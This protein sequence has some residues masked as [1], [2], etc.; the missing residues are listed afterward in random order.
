MRKSLGTALAVGFLTIAA[1][2]VAQTAPQEVRVT[3]VDRS[4]RAFFSAQ[5]FTGSGNFWISPRTT[6]R[7][8]DQ[9]TTYDYFK[10]GSVVR[11]SSHMEGD[12]AIADDVM[13]IQ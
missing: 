5:W 12:K 10:T 9:P 4:S 6:F 7:V 11:V 8:G 13:F 3:A 1:A 2:A